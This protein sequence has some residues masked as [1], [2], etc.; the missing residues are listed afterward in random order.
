MLEGMKGAGFSTNSKLSKFYTDFQR[1]R[2]E[3]GF[4]ANLSLPGTP[5]ERYSESLIDNCKEFSDK[6]VV[7]IARTG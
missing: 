4:K 2:P 3:S 7:V 6:A 1:K 5:V